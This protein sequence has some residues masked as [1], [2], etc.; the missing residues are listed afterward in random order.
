LFA[1]ETGSNIIPCEAHMARDIAMI[2][3][4]CR[5]AGDGAGLR[6]HAVTRAKLA[7]NA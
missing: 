1:D 7:G 2:T 3:D 6:A 4:I 5:Q